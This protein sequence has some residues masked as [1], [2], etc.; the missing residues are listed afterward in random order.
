MSRVIL[1][2]LGSHLKGMSGFS[3]FSNVRVVGYLTGVTLHIVAIYFFPTYVIVE[4]LHVVEDTSLIS[5]HAVVLFP[6]W[7]HSGWFVSNVVWILLIL[8][9]ILW[10]TSDNAIRENIWGLV[11][12][13]IG[14]RWLMA[15]LWALATE[16]LLVFNRQFNDPLHL[17]SLNICIH[18]FPY[19]MF[20][21]KLFSHHI[22]M[23]L[24]VI[25]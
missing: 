18:L 24:Y 8:L 13:M 3:L 15:I 20:N 16:I 5:L 6:V 22:F 25:F 12:W 7:V 9:V 21:G 19:V 4:V 17:S 1:I 23:H 14:E 10:S 2:C 11:V